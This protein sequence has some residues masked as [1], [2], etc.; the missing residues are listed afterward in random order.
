M[1]FPTSHDIGLYA[2]ESE[3]KQYCKTKTFALS[4]QMWKDHVSLDKHP[5]DTMLAEFENGTK[6][7]RLGV[8][9]TRYRYEKMW[10]RKSLK[11]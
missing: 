4:L 6:F 9:F 1:I 8:E 11:P 5:V 10:N 7:L 3:I 2:F